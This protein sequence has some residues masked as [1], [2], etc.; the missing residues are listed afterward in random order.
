MP[1]KII[2]RL[3]VSHLHAIIAQT[4]QI[5]Y[6][7]S[8]VVVYQPPGH[9]K[10]ARFDNEIW[11]PIFKQEFVR[12][13]KN[14]KPKPTDAFVCTYPKCGTTWTQHILSQLMMEHYGPDIGKE[15]CVTSPMI[16][17]MGAKFVE[18][19]VHPRLLKTHFEWRN[20]PKSR[21]AKYVFVCRN[22]KDCVVSYYFHNRNFKIYDFTDGDFNTFFDLFMEGRLGFGDYFDHLL[23]WLP[24]LSDPNVLFLRFEDML[25]DLPSAIVKLGKFVGGRSSELVDDNEVLK[26]ITEQSKVEAMAQDQWRWFPEGNMNPNQRPFIRQ[27]KKRDW[28]N[29]LSKEQSD[30]M[31]ALF[32][33]RMKGTIAEHWWQDEMSWD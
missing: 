12:S 21:D 2:D 16:E 5:E 3:N 17:R 14:Y 26:R 23:G 20:V 32:K 28:I 30:R 11:P 24:H 22:P 29:Y 1:N 13:A 6:K 8:D 7:Q 31:D 25:Q 4:E 19:L 18:N 27:G 10:Q 33:L 15:L 9:P